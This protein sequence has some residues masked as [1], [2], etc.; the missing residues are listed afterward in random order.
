[1]LILQLLLVA[2]FFY[3]VRKR[4]KTACAYEKRKYSVAALFFTIGLGVSAY[5]TFGI[6]AEPAASSMQ[7]LLNTIALLLT[8]ISVSEL[9][10]TYL[11]FRRREL[12]EQLKQRH[13]EQQGP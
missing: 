9:I 11:L 2:V 4:R 10:L 12:L 1:M 8:L 13:T 6:S 7:A 3:I 5:A